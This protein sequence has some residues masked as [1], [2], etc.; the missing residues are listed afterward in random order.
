MG[1]GLQNEMMVGKIMISGSMALSGSQNN[2]IVYIDENNDK[3]GI[4]SARLTKPNYNITELVKSIDTNIVELIPIAA[5]ELPDTVLRS[6]YNPVTQSV[7]DLT[8]QIANLNQSIQDL[9]AKVTSLEVVT[10]SLKVEIDNASLSVATYQ[11][12]S[13][14]ANSKVQSSISEL[15]NAIQKA[16]GESIQRVSLNARNQVLTEQVA[17]LRA[18][19]SAKEQAVAAGGVSTGQLATILFDKGDP[20]KSTQAVMISMDYGGGYGSTASKDKFAASND[21]LTSTYRSYFDVIAGLGADVTVDV[22]FSGGMSQSPFNFGGLP[23]T[24]KKGA[25]QRFDMT[26]ASSYLKGLPGQH[27]GGLFSHSSP[28]VYNFTMSIKVTDGKTTENKD[29]TM[30]IYNHN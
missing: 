20:T 24:I 17:T 28:T 8:A 18:Q 29:F 10:Q 26:S 13:G 14:Q 19:L 23:A 2:G 16:T 5:P 4:I 6:I 1:N 9:T 25:K 15:Q 7:I 22:T 3:T 21:P 11:N 30:R 27:G 12:Q